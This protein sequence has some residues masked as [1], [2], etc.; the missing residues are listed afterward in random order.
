M[1][2]PLF[3]VHKWVLNASDDKGPW[4]ECERCGGTGNVPE[5]LPYAGTLDEY[6]YNL[7]RDLSVLSAFSLPDG[8][9]AAGVMTWELGEFE[10]DLERLAKEGLLRW[11]NQ[12]DQYEVML[13]EIVD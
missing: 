8:A 1:I 10:S 12:T 11:N 3:C 7:W 6:Q 5:D 2:Q 9:K 13:H 4:Y